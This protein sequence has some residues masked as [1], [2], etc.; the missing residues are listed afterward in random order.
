MLILA[1]VTRQTKATNF[2]VNI[3]ICNCICTI[4]SCVV[5]SQNVHGVAIKQSYVG[6]ITYFTNQVLMYN[7]ERWKIASNVISPRI[8]L[9]WLIQCAMMSYKLDNILH[10]GFFTAR[11]FPITYSVMRNMFAW[12]RK[13]LYNAFTDLGR[14]WSGNVRNTY[15]VGDYTQI[16]R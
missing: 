3:V 9:W 10:N 16:Y 5:E 12:T 11:Y 7:K 4:S 1:M 8:T 15:L 6:S 14:L 13:T 2:V